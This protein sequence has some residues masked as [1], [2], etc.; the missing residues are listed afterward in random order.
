MFA[1][2]CV[3][4][5]LLLKNKHEMSTYLNRGQ[6]FPKMCVYTVSSLKKKDPLIPLLNI[7]C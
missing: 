7:N 2:F 6:N 3:L 5:F 4:D 1:P